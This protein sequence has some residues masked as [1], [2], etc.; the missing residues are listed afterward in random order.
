MLNIIAR[1]GPA[2]TALALCVVLASTL[3]DLHRGRDNLE[4]IAAQQA[5]GVRTDGKV[6]SQLESLAKGTQALASAGN[7]NAQRIVAILKQNGVN[8]KGQ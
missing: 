7:P 2:L 4:K 3:A 5:Q 8:I 6:Q 1:L